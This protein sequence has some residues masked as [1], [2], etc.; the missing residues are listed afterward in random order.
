[1]N[2]VVVIIQ[3]RMID[4]EKVNLKPDFVYLH[5][6]PTNLNF[7]ICSQLVKS[8]WAFTHPLSSIYIE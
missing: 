8:I 6:T 7:S 2:I 4:L 3:D 1:M 5:I